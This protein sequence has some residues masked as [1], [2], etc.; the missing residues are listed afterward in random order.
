[1]RKALF[2]CIILSVIISAC[3]PSAPLPND[4][5]PNNQIAS[6]ITLDNTKITGTDT[7]SLP[8]N[9]QIPTDTPEPTPTDTPKPSP[10]ATSVS[11]IPWNVPT[12][13]NENFDFSAT[14]LLKW[15]EYHLIEV[16]TLEES[17]TVETVFKENHLYLMPE[18]LYYNEHV[19]RSKN[20]LNMNSIIKLVLPAGYN[21]NIKEKRLV[22]N[23]NGEILTLGIVEN[24]FG[25]DNSKFVLLLN[26]TDMRSEVQGF[27]TEKE[28]NPNS[29][30]FI[31][32]MENLEQ[33]MVNGELLTLQ[34]LS[35]YQQEIGGFRAGEEIS[36]FDIFQPI[37]SFTIYLDGG[38]K[39]YLLGTEHLTSGF[40]LLGRREDSLIDVVGEPRSRCLLQDPGSFT[41]LEGTKYWGTALGLTKDEDLVFKID[42]EDKDRYFF[43]IEPIFSNIDMNKLTD[44]GGLTANEDDSRI[45]YGAT[46]TLVKEE[47]EGQ[48]E[49]LNTLSQNYDRYIANRGRVPMVIP[50]GITMEKYF[51]GEGNIEKLLGGRD[52]PFPYYPYTQYMKFVGSCED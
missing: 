44:L 22:Q 9:T 2:V 31:N 17:V 23:E 30:T 33:E 7:V 42:S 41:V 13:K 3:T 29:I 16:E 39:Q 28:R 36:L 47:P 43:K 21:F 10:T 27:V 52:T 18:G 34:R 38:R 11:N 14:D 51:L 1:M 4:D 12:E 20:Y 50:Q 32:T 40:N 48:V 49:M 8:T 25:V 6:E 26:A 46:V 35:E 37:D 45:I 15:N 19:A 24:S 5:I